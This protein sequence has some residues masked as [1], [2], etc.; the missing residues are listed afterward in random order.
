MPNEHEEQASEYAVKENLAG[1]KRR[2]VV[3]RTDAHQDA[4]NC[5]ADGGSHCEQ[6]ARGA[7]LEEEVTIEDDDAYAQQG[8]HRAPH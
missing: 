1:D 3:L 6:I 8:N 4:G 2:T 5:P 7:G